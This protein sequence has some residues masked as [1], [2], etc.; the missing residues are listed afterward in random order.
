MRPPASG[1]QQSNMQRAAKLD[2]ARDERDLERFPSSKSQAVHLTFPHLTEILRDKGLRG[3][4]T[5]KHQWHRRVE[6]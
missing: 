3:L 4:A 6:F 1:G 2:Q 5:R